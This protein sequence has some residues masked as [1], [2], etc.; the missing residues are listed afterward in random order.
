MLASI[1]DIHRYRD[2]YT[3]HNPQLTLQDESLAEAAEVGLQRAP[4]TGIV[5]ASSS[6]HFS[7]GSIVITKTATRQVSKLKNV[8]SLEN[9]QRWVSQQRGYYDPRSKSAPKD[10]QTVLVKNPTRFRK[11]GNFYRGSDRRIYQEIETGHL[12]Y[13][14]DAHP[15]RSAH[16]EVFDSDGNH[17]GIADIHAGVIDSA[18]KVPGRTIKL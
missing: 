2:Q 4:D 12:F 17:L 7:E 5:S 9:I 10:F 13:V 3:C 15:G 18:Q 8:I 11:T 16:L 6:I 14:D 1:E